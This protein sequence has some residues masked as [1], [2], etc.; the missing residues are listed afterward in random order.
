MEGKKGA[1]EWMIEFKNPPAD[2]SQSLTW[3][4]LRSQTK[5]QHD[6]KPTNNNVAKK[7]ILR[8][9]KRPRQV[10]GNIKPEIQPKRLFRAVEKHAV[11]TV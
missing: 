2:V 3:I 7:F 8:L 9:V 4:R 6:I 5:Q 10:V 11:E 1:H